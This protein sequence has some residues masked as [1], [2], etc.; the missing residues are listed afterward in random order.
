M[1]PETAGPNPFDGGGNVRIN[2]KTRYETVCHAVVFPVDYEAL[3]LFRERSI[4]AMMVPDAT[5]TPRP[6]TSLPDDT[7]ARPGAQSLAMTCRHLSS[8]GH[9]RDV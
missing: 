3:C 1:S 9:S 2:R 6:D 8:S 7:P 4:T 5:P